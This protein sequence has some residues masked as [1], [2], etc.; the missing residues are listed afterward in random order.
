M[1]FSSLDSLLDFLEPIDKYVISNDEGYHQLQIGNRVHAYE[2]HFPEIENADLILIG[3]N[4]FRGVAQKKS[5]PAAA[6]L[7]RKQFYH[8][9]L[10]H[11]D[12]TIADVGNL[13]L[14]ASVKDTYA[15]LKTVVDELLNYGKRVVILGGSHD[16]TLAQ[17]QIYG[18]RQE[19]IEATCVD[20]KI[21]IN[22]DS[23]FPADKFLMQMLTSE[24]NFVKHYNHIGF[25]SY[26]VHPGL[27][28]TIDKL[29]FDCY[30]VGKVRENIE[31]ME[32]VIRSSKL[33][34]FDISAI[35]PAFAPANTVSP[36]GFSGEEACSLMQYAGMSTHVNTI[37]IYG[38]HPSKDV[39]QL[40]AM[41][42]AQML[43]Y[44]IDGIYKSMN[45]VNLKENENFIE[46]KLAFAQVETS[47]KQSKKTGRWWM[48]LPDGSFIACSYN[49][50]IIASDNEIPER[51][52]RAVERS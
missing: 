42:I 25:Q 7:V 46:Y 45:E 30:R 52:M 33:F 32:P 9:Y 5:E 15:A 22:M 21:D 8:L 37:G 26:L 3:C 47:F 27:L 4:E 50:Y 38:Y 10:W 2:E 34:S 48:E 14:G 40:T 28:E 6:D 17:Y 29:R 39:H 13:R 11:A 1:S 43:W 19:I 49:D 24:P 16:L 36:N 44:L 41:Q 20:A 35:Q 31:E 18:D 51:W 23:P 12:I